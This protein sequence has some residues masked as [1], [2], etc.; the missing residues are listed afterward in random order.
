MC[1]YNV[2][3]LMTRYRGID[4]RKDPHLKCNNGY[5]PQVDQRDDG[6]NVNPFEIIFV[7]VKDSPWKRD[8]YIVR[9]Y[10]DYYMGR[11]DITKS[12]WDSPWVQE[13]FSVER[14]MLLQR[15]KRC[16]AT[17]D[18]AYYV[19]L[20]PDTKVFTTYDELLLHFLD[21][22]FKERRMYRFEPD[23]AVLKDPRKA[24]ECSNIQAKIVEFS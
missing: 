9:T 17:F 16:G 19:K 20:N 11:D 1:R 10:T 4:W 18:T 22:G 24:Q 12:K 13:S 15:V 5:N 14:E 8:A 2:D 21:Y 3:C 7:K 23:P 6:H